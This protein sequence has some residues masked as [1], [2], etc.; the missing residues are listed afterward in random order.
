MDQDIRQKMDIGDQ[1]IVSYINSWEKY[2]VAHRGICHPFLDKYAFEGLGFDENATLFTEFYYF[3]RYLPFY[4]AGMAM[5]TRD[6]RILREIV[7]NVAEEVGERDKTPH[8]D[9]YR[10]FLEALG[11]EG[12]YIDQ[13]T[14]L[15][16]TLD[17]DD[18]VKDL[19]TN[20]PIEKGLGA[21]YAL[22]TMSSL[23][24]E[25]LNLGLEKSGYDGQERAFFVLH[26]DG[27]KGH[28]NGAYNAISPYLNV[29][30]NKIYFEDGIKRFMNLIERFW[31]GIAVR[32][33]EKNSLVQHEA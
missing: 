16:S 31:D 29:K 8:L 22:E 13:Y 9:I 19:Y 24:V 2:I 23:M 28:S 20:S 25:K 15:Q 6:E 21:M 1:A 5:R 30:A 11:V 14:C 26:I 10:R 3:I 17:L 27:E 4:I 33:A 32:I 18:G 7:I 12:V